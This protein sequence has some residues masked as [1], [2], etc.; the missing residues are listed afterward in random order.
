[1]HLETLDLHNCLVLKAQ[2]WKMLLRSYLQILWLFRARLVFTLT[3]QKY[4]QTGWTLW[5]GIKYWFSL[6]SITAFCFTVFVGYNN[7][8]RL[9]TLLSLNITERVVCMG[10]NMHM[11][12]NPQALDKTI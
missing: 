12:R 10:A 1:M 2:E 6:I 9:I 5:K 4:F 3:L 11:W 8:T 7:Y